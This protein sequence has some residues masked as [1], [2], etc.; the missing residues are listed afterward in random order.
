[1]LREVNGTPTLK[2]GCFVLSQLPKP[3]VFMVAAHAHW[4]IGNALHWQFGVSLREDAARSRK[5]NGPTNIAV[6][7]RRIFVRR[8]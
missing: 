1:M 3:E 7:R 2:T 8:R 5:N 6:L 4:A